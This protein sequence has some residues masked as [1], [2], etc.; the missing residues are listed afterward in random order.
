MFFEIVASARST[1]RCSM[2]RRM[3]LKPALAATWTMPLPIVPPPITPIVLMSAIYLFLSL[4]CHRYCISAAET[5]R[6]NSAF[7]IAPR[8]FI[9][10]RHEN[11]GAACADGMSQCDSAAVHIDS[12]GIQFQ[13]F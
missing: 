12:F 10:Q 4:H 3:T 8:H 2:S 5:Q 11:T 13:L 1:K 9:K 6:G 7:G